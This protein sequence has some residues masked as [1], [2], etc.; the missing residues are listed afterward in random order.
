MSG[1]KS[2]NGV[3]VGAEERGR[4]EDGSDGGARKTKKG[5]ALTYCDSATA[6]GFGRFMTSIFVGYCMR[7]LLLKV[8]TKT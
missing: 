7:M 4:G 6:S 2:L 1:W 8:C 5:K 3:G